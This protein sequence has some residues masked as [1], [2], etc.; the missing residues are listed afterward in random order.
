MPAAIKSFAGS[1]TIG[2][3]LSSSPV[4]EAAADVVEDLFGHLHLFPGADAGGDG[5]GPQNKKTHSADR[6]FIDPFSR[7]DLYRQGVVF[8]GMEDDVQRRRH[9][10]VIPPRTS[11]LD[12]QQHTVLLSLNLLSV[13]VLR[14]EPAT[15]VA[16]YR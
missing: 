13:E 1:K 8:R 2:A 15:H 7:A 4:R 10:H 9:A 3:I 16:D 5:Q 11:L 14:V 12:L 6:G